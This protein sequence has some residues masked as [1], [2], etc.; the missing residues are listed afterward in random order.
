MSDYISN[1]RKKIGH[2]PLI[3]PHSVVIIFNENDEVLFEERSDDG[4]YDFPGGGVDLNET[5]EEAAKR[6]LFEET[7]LI[8]DELILFKVYNGPITYYKYVNGD[9]IYGVDAIYISKK[10]HG[11][12]KP[13]ESEVSRLFFMNID[14]VPNDKLSMRNKQIII[15]LKARK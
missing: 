7:G 2:D 4:F 10:Y 9:E 5:F 11:E 6:E 1:I 8:A 3:I 14:D 13:Q 12:L 15:D